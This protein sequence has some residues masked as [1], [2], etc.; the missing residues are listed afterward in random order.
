M[1]IIL[2]YYRMV[3]EEVVR[4]IYEV[5]RPEPT[6]EPEQVNEP[7]EDPEEDHVVPENAADEVTLAEEDDQEIDVLVEVY[8]MIRDLIDKNQELEVR[9]Q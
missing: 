3:E 6:V 8:A 7:E 9:S 4:D 1:W 5:P 2:L